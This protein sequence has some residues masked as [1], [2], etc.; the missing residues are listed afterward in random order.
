[1]SGGHTRQYYSTR[2][3]HFPRFNW[4]LYTRTHGYNSF[5]KKIGTLS[6]K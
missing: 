4:N 3:S 2:Y 5:V 6:A 1:M